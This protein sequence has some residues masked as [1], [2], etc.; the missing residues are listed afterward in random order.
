MWCR[1]EFFHCRTPFNGPTF[2]VNSSCR[3]LFTSIKPLVLPVLWIFHSFLLGC[4]NWRQPCETFCC[5]LSSYHKQKTVIQYHIQLRL[6][7]AYSLMIRIISLIFTTTNL[8]P[9]FMQSNHSGI[10]I[11][12][13]HTFF[14]SFLGDLINK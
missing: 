10:C 6:I 4:I 5:Q 14:L 12:C 8:N 2:F 11:S 7:S 3:Y 9:K 13:H 1:S